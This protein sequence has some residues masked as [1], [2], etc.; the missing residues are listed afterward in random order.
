MSMQDRRTEADGGCLGF[1]A[2]AWKRACPSQQAA[3]AAQP[4]PACGLPPLVC[5]CNVPAEL[6]RAPLN[7]Y[8]QHPH[9]PP[10]VQPRAQP[11][12]RTSTHRTPPASAASPARRPRPPPPRLPS[13]SPPRPPPHR[14]RTRR[15]PPRCCSPCPAPCPP[16]LPATSSSAWAPAAETRPRG[17]PLSWSSG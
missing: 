4:R 5:V 15:R 17:A 11:A 2:G 9:S 1:P 6:R 14:P 10:V 3:G 16:Q 7:P 12:C 13:R 8:R